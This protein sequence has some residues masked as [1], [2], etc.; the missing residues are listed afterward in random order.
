MPK[1]DYSK[2]SM[3]EMK[4]MKAELENAMATYEERKRSEAIAAAEA[5][6]RE[7]GFSLS[8]LTGTKIKT[9]TTPKYVSPDDPSLTWSGRGR[10]PRWLQDALDAGKNL[11]DFKI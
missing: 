3:D 4:R 6:V 11:E 9:G 8:Q 7:H 10:K 2:L 1:I 5:A